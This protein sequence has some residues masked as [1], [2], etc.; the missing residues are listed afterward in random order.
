MIE[1][2][3]RRIFATQRGKLSKLIF[4]WTFPWDAISTTFLLQLPLSWSIESS[5]KHT[6]KQK[7]KSI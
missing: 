1:A 6:P 3:Y 2:Q 4:S 7:T 5:L